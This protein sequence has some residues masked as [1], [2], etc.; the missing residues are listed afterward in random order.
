LHSAQF[1]PEGIQFVIAMIRMRTK[2]HHVL[3]LLVRLSNSSPNQRFN[4]MYH[5]T[6][7][8]ELTFKIFLTFEYLRGL[9]ALLYKAVLV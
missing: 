3:R 6:I 7:T 9:P 4:S 8:V 2:L 5:I 1:G